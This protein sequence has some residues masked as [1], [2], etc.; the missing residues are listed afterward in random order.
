[1][2]QCKKATDFFT[3]VLLIFM[4]I[5]VL[6]FLGLKSNNKMRNLQISNDNKQEKFEFSYPANDS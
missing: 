3:N 5:I 1:M 6:S 4:A 2:T